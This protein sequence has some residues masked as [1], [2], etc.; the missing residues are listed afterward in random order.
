M[1]AP[2]LPDLMP[3]M[4]RTWLLDLDGTVVKHNG[5]L[6]GGDELLPGVLPLWA[7]MGPEDVIVILTARPSTHRAVTEDFLRRQGL[8]FDQL[9]MDLPH[10]ER[11]LFNDR[12]PDGSA[13]AHAFNLARDGGFSA[14]LVE[15]IGR[16][17]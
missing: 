12:K 1:N 8:R 4:R 7:A 9:I 11:L 13:T 10:G 2:A 6:Q 5:H 3:G 16:A 17:R 14:A 15:A